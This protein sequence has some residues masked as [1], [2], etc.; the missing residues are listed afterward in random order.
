MHYC[1]VK[2]IYKNILQKK[3]DNKIQK[4]MKESKLILDIITYVDS[5][6][7]NR[8]DDGIPIS[9]VQAM[10]V[11]QKSSSK[12]VSYVKSLENNDGESTSSLSHNNNNNLMN[13]VNNS[14][15]INGDFTF[16]YEEDVHPEVFFVPYIW[17]VIVKV[18]THNLLEWNSD[19]ISLLGD[20]S[21]SSSGTST[22]SACGAGGKDESSA[23]LKNAED[24]V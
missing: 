19:K 3:T 5:L 7:R 9:A 11:L 13:N 2:L 18:V 24:I 21:N 8:L 15:N 23:L 1:T 22:S 10:E 20:T 16:I 17:E 14:N 6:I 4:E 12:V